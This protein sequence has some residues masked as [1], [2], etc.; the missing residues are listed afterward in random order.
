MS[1]TITLNMAAED[2][3]KTL[4]SYD[5]FVDVGVCDNSLIVYVEHM[6]GDLHHV[7]TT[8]Y[9]HQVKIWFKQ[10]LFAK[11]TFNTPIEIDLGTC[12]EEDEIERH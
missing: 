2:L 1:K 7:P 8:L 10:Y 6:G 9:G 5:W 12:Q 4:D 11:E 3:A